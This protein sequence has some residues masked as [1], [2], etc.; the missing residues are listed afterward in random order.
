MKTPPPVAPELPG[1]PRPPEPPTIASG[2]I[3]SLVVSLARYLSQTE[4]HTYAFSVAANAILSLF[5]LIVML[6]TLARNVFHSEAMEQAIG[7]MLR[8]FLPTGQDFVVKNM[9]I[10]ADAHRG[11]RIAAV[12]MLLVSSSGVFVPLEVALN[13]VWGVTRNRSYL[14]NQ[15]V[16]TGLAV[17]VCILALASVALTALHTSILTLLFFGHTQ[18]FVFRFI[19]QVLLQI[20]A[21]FLSVAVFFFVYWILPYRKLPPS[22]VL[23]T[24]VVT[25][26]AWDLLKHFY[27]AALPWLDFRAVYGPFATSVGLM[28]WAFVTGLMLLAGAHYSATR[29]TLRIVHE[30][31]LQEDVKFVA[32]R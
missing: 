32:G 27:V 3:V 8:Y 13:Q 17:I 20:S 28:L 15:L 6:L 25:G 30:A 2:G 21:A 23:P 1:T 22:A 31:D 26:L 9:T 12:L 19:T 16:S 24:A 14:L 18:N 29:Y 7:A 4:V 5:P 10:V 11:V